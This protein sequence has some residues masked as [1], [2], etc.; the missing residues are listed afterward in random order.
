MI[1]S[2]RKKISKALAFV[3]ICSA[4]FISVRLLTAS[5]NASAQTKEVSLYGK[6]VFLLGDS[7]VARFLGDSYVETFGQ[8]SSFF[9]KPGATPN[10]YLDD[11]SL[12]ATLREYVESNGNPDIIVIQLGDNGIS[13]AAKVSKM[14]S[15]TLEISPTSMIVWSG[16]M[17]AVAPTNGSSSYVSEDPSSSRYL[18]T[19]NHTRRLWNQ[20]AQDGASQKNAFFIDNY[21]L[22]E[23]AVGGQTF[24]DSRKGDGVH[25]TIES[26]KTLS[27][28]H[29]EILE[30]VLKDDV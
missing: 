16:P 29:K 4:V 8:Q 21:A 12:W 22:Q 15:K 27:K 25:L 30:R 7:Q 3:G 14:I 2:N 11:D 23:Q 13:S 1:K 10:T 5:K 20:R 24:S 28:I 19:Y 6:S 9:G 18:D 26:A 17:K